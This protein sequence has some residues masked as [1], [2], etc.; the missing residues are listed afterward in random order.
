MRLASR[1]ARHRDETIQTR[2]KDLDAGAA[3]TNK[4]LDRANP[5]VQSGPHHMK[6]LDRTTKTIELTIHSSPHEVLGA[7]KA[8][9]GPPGKADEL[10][11][12]VVEDYPWTSEAIVYW[13]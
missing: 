5:N 2:R 12:A 9:E 7:L 10:R 8:Q 11:Q 1:F 6:V 4:P 13:R 3:T